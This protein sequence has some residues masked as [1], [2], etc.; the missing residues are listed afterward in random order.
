M[1]KHYKSLYGGEVYLL[2]NI[3]KIENPQSNLYQK[4]TQPI[5]K[6]K[7]LQKLQVLKEQLIETANLKADL[8]LVN[9]LK[10]LIQAYVMDVLIV[11]KLVVR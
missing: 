5:M 9:H 11:E 4:A 6:E 8:I 2:L 1:L 10:M 3:V 7:H